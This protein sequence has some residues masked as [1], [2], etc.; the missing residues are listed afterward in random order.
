[1]RHMT[2]AASYGR[3]A[4]GASLEAL[5]IIAIVITLALG[6]ALAF[7]TSPA[8]ENVFAARG[9]GG[10]TVTISLA[11]DQARLSSLSGDASFA[12]TRS[13]ADNDPVLW[14]T[15]KCYAAD[16]T[17]VSQLDLPVR[18]GTS[19]SLTGVAGAYATSGARCNAYATVRPWQSRVFGG[20]TMWFDVAG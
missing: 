3:R 16:G 18:W 4:F 10:M 13:V 15:T 14:V 1:M 2:Q 5:A 6:I 19:D 7:G 8:A 12:V 17:L 11:G 20:A 9:G